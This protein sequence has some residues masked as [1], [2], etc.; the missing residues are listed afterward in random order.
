MNQFKLKKKNLLLFSVSRFSFT[1]F[2]GNSLF[3]CLYI[4][5]FFYQTVLSTV[6]KYL[7]QKLKNWIDRFS[8]CRQLE[9]MGQKLYIFKIWPP[10]FA[11]KNIYR[12]LNLSKTINELI[13]PINFFFVKIPIFEKNMFCV[14][15]CS[16]F[17]FLI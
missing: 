3:L 15:N 17:F 12:I 9:K 5:L 13:S 7:S 10:D 2:N 14:K 11:Q 6:P 4:S 16:C 1:I 8:I